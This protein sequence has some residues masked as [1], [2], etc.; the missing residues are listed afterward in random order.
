MNLVASE[1][2]VGKPKHPGT[3]VELTGDHVIRRGGRRGEPDDA[4]H[5]G[6]HASPAADLLQDCL[7]DKRHSHGGAEGPEL[8]VASSP[9][10]KCEG[11][12]G[13]RRQHDDYRA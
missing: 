11:D 5:L 9:E 7:R 8:A 10:Q 3:V 1:E 2:N 12:P 4:D 6:E 13:Y